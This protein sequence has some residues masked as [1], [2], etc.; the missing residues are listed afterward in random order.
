MK[1][2][3][4]CLNLRK[5][6][7]K[8]I[9]ILFL[10]SFLSSSTL[11]AQENNSDLKPDSPN[12][13][14]ERFSFKMGGFVTALN[15]DIQISSQQVGL[16][17]LVNVEDA[18]G[19]STSSSV[20]RSEIQYNFGKTRRH[21]A[22]LD[23]FGL[24]RHA[25]KILDTEI[26]IGDEIYPIGTEVS[27]KFNLR[28]FKG[29]YAYSFYM[30]ERVKIDASLGLFI[31]PISFSSSALKSSRETASFTAPLPVVGL[32]TSFAITPK[33]YLKQSVEVLYLDISN[34]KGSIV[35]VN[36][37]LEYNRWKH[38]GLGLGLN[39]YRLSIE[40]DTEDNPFFDFQGSVKTGYSG[41]LFYGKYYF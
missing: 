1:N 41:L 19:L 27:S 22:K 15:S 32:G 5:W 25:Q 3:P 20:I 16:G 24:F 14:W 21:S 9:F 35:D 17:A 40:A 18:L 26:E 28:I 8:M 39:A 4:V 33:L 10:V 2:H 36:M 6:K 7:N 37:R 11:S 12:Y 30:D 23:Y 31:M 29:T 38:F 34:V 13:S